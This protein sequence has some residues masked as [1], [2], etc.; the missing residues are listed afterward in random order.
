MRYCHFGVSPVNNSD[1]E[2]LKLVINLSSVF[3]IKYWKW[4]EIWW[5][6]ELIN[7]VVKLKVKEIS[8]MHHR[9]VE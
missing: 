4:S 6:H 8:I 2:K 5:V 3:I 7:N 9:T 1:S